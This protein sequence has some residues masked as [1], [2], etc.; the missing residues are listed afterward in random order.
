MKASYLHNY[1]ITDERNPPS[2]QN[3]ITVDIFK[4]HKM[5]A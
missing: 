2:N 1:V 4:H 3:L 5:N